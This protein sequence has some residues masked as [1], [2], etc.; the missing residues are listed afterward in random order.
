MFTFSFYL[1]GSI[2]SYLDFKYFTVP[3]ILV[4]TAFILLLFF[5]FIEQQLNIYSFAIA[6]LVLLFF[7]AVLLLN[8]KMILGGGDIKY[9]MLVAIYLDPFVF[10]YFLIIT[11]VLQTLLLL[12]KKHIFK[13]R[14][15]PMVPMIFL[16]VLVCDL[17]VVLNMIVLKA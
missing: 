1:F 11:G 12:V 6:I 2:L 17:L 7:V 4:F 16:S 10:P 9:I 3:N 8:P 13:R 14:V 15:A 5:G